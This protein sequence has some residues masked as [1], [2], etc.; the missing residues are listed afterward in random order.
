MNLN[1]Y[2]ICL[3]V[4]WVQHN[5]DGSTESLSWQVL[6]E[7]SS[8]ETVVTVSSGNFTPDDSDFRSSN[9]LRSSVDV[10]DSLT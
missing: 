4:G 3:D 2:I 5:S 7:V 9:F 1:L 6:F 8:N 10:G